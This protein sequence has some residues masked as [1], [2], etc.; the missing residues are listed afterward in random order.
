MSRASITTIFDTLH[1]MC[2]VD[3]GFS[4]VYVGQPTNMLDSIVMWRI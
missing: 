1:V 2:F 4:V 3:L